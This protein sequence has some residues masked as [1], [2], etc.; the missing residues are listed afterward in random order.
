MPQFP[1][2]PSFKLRGK[3]ALVAGASSGIGMACAVA[4][5]EHGAEVTLAARRT[6]ALQQIAK[7]MSARGWLAE[8]LELD[9]SDVAATSEAVAQSGPFDILLNSAGLA[10]HSKAVD[11]QPEDFDAVMGVNVKG[12]YFLTQAVA[13]GLLDA[14]R[15]GSLINISSQM[16]H[17]GGRERAVYC[18]SKF[19]VEG[20][21]KAMAL[22]FGPAKIRVNT[23]CPTFILTD[24]TRA[25]FD[26]PDK[27]AW[28]LDKIKL[29][30]PGEIEDIMGAVVYLASD[31]S[32]L[33]TGTAMMID[34]GW[35]AD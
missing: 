19:A 22:E 23:I 35:T 30:R 6:G 24:L 2:T 11:T 17:V 9:V 33:V 16:G 7:D 28:I 1:S 8:V 14:G 25:T 13:K 26:D 31:A 32:A 15:S 12:A 27:R 18:A 29:G 20:F 21:S 34:G 3:R 5:A 4:L 10:R